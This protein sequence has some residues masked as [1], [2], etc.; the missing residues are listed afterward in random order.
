MSTQTVAPADPNAAYDPKTPP[1]Y[2]IAANH[3]ASVPADDKTEPY[4]TEFFIKDDGSKSAS[5][6]SPSRPVPVAAP[7]V[8]PPAA[9]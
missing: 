3:L 5:N 9:S 6:E 2:G 4:P 8:T 1:L 7:V